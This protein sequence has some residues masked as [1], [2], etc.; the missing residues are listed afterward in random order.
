MELLILYYISLQWKNDFQAE[1]TQIIH[2]LQF[3]LASV[4]GT[5]LSI[6]LTSLHQVFIYETPVLSSLLQ[7]WRYAPKEDVQA[8]GQGGD[9]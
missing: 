5:S 9:A 4:T 1:N 3:S 6:S 7:F 8:Q 2:R